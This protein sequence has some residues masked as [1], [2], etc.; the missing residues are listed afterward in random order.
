MDRPAGSG[1]RITALGGG[2]GLSRLLRGLKVCSENV[3]AI[4]TTADDGGSSG[5]LRNDLG[6]IPPGDIRSCILALANTEP[7]MEQLINYRFTEGSL[8]GQ[9][10]GN[11]F[12]AA[13][14]GVSGSF[15]VAVRHL[16]DV[17]AVT[18]R[19]LPVSAEPSCLTAVF[20]NGAEVTGESC[21]SGY[22]KAEKHR[23]RKIGL[24]RPVKATDDALEAIV[25]ADL[26]V[27]GPGSLYTSVIPNLLIGGVADA[28]K[29]S[30]A[31][32]V[33]V[34][35]IMTQFGETEGYTCFDHAGE[36]IK[37]AGGPVIDA[38]L[39]NTASVPEDVLV[40]YANENAEAA[41]IDRGLFVKAGIELRER[42]LLF[43]KDGQVRHHP[44]RLAQ[45]LME[46]LTEKRPRAGLH[47]QADESL[48]VWLEE[49][50]DA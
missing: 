14:T 33:Y 38:C 19:V 12:L 8:A 36:I 41:D 48:L 49:T 37:H 2:T 43:L 50:L 39:V 29:A 4:V 9:N 16:S 25:D 32:R 22:K 47:G 35:N 21:I 28:L 44:L 1:V 23:I 15:E 24:K 13:L 11:L 18:G 45:S 46:L 5:L 31:L 27:L 17:L 42:P 40:R 7:T 10:F 30:R 26:V 6:I 20:D 34:C 3:T